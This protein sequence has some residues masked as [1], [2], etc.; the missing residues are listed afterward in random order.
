MRSSVPPVRFERTVIGL[1]VRCV[2]HCATGDWLARVDLNH[3]PPGYQPGALPGELRASGRRRARSPARDGALPRSKRRPQPR[4][5]RL[6]CADDGG[7]D[8]QPVT[9]PIPLRTGGCPLTASSSR[10]DGTGFEPAHDSCR[11]LRFPAGHLA[12]SVSHPGAESGA[13]EAHALRR[14]LASNEAR[15][16]CPVHSPCVPSLGLEPRRHA[17]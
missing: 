5:L 8:P 11:D 14:A 2:D 13:V 10:A 6:P 17:V 12:N 7:P 4:R 16:A 9:G 1:K 15:C 3:L